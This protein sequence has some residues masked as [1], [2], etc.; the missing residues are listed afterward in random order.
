MNDLRGREI[1]GWND[2]IG[3]DHLAGWFRRQILSDRLAHA[4]LFEGPA[5]VGKKQM[6]LIFAQAVNC[7]R[8]DADPCGECP[9]CGRVGAQ[10]DPGLMIYR[11]IDEGSWI[12]RK[13]AIE[14]AGS[15][16][17]LLDAYA[18]LV[19]AG[20]LNPPVP[21]G[22]GSDRWDRVVLSAEKIFRRGRAPSL[23]QALEDLSGLEGDKVPEA[24]GRVGTQLFRGPQS[25]VYYRK[26]MG[27]DLVT[28]RS[29]TEE[30]RTIRGFLS[31]KRLGGRRK[32]VIVD[33]A[34]KMTEEAQNS[35]LKTL[36]EPPQDS[37]LILVLDCASELLPTIRS[38]CQRVGFGI[39]PADVL[40]GALENRGFEREEAQWAAGTSSGRFARALGSRREDSV[41][42]REEILH[43]WREIYGGDLAGL[44]G[45]AGFLAHEEIPER[46][47][48]VRRVREQLDGLILWLRDLLFVVHG[49]SRDLLVNAD[50][51]DSLSRES[52]RLPPQV[53]EQV[54]WAVAETSRRLDRN[55]DV[56]LA[57]EGMALTLV[58]IVKDRE[59]VPV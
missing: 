55:V 31:R 15:E 8:G 59:V 34:H 1:M 40:A 32:I 58:S 41:V 14:W 33:D 22:R 4:Y 35:L 48:R 6:A 9:S 50:L 29:R 17:L 21:G 5:G 44:M 11:D 46:G 19:D 24:A 28:A 47:A 10:D 7:S 13:K 49:A 39:I 45:E 23:S 27:I 42:A 18:Y 52:R 37:L 57:L 12:P 3:H 56:R 2:V 43:T 26:S 20:F 51:A 53:L 30:A 16:D 38:R 54:F 36:E 25:L